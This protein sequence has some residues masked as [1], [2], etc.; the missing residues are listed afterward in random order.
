MSLI[1]YTRTVITCWCIV[2]PYN[3]KGL[4]EPCFHTSPGETNVFAVETMAKYG[5]HSLY[6]SYLILAHEALL[7]EG[8]IQI[9]TTS[10]VWVPTTEHCDLLKLLD[11]P[12][13]FSK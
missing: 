7:F 2:N 11:L 3:G 10:L 6:G 13:F 12:L 9:C 8:R 1:Y 5:D 4:G